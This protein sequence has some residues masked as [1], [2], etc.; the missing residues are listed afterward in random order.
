DAYLHGPREKLLY[1]PC[2]IPDHSRPDYIATVDVDPE[3]AT[4]LQV[5]HRLPMPHLGDELHHSGWNSCSSCFADPNAPSRRLL[6]LPALG[7][8]RV[9]GVDTA[10][11]PR[12][13]RLAAVAEPKDIQAA[14]GLS[15]LHTSHCAPDGSIMVSAMGDAEG[16]ARGSFLLLNQDLSG[17]VTS[18]ASCRL[19]LCTRTCSVKGLWSSEETPYGYDFWYQPRLNVMIS[20]G[21]GAPKIFS[22]LSLDGKRLYVTNSLYSPWDKQ[23]YPSMV[24]GG[25]HVLKIDVDTEK[26]GLSLD[27]NWIVDFAK[28]PEGPVLAHEIRYPGGDCSSDIWI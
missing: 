12:A 11:D 17:D 15:Y 14:T 23:F 16:S 1:I 4:H 7:S 25:S 5:I 9:Y 21:W 24:E 22:K 10:T 13:P 26:G 18:P 28:E 19:Y 3:S 20:S 6:V 2:V 27:T 8:G